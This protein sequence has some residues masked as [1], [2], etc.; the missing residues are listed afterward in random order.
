MFSARS[1]DR[2]LP[3]IAE[4]RHLKSMEGFAQLVNQERFEQLDSPSSR[5]RRH[6]QPDFACT[7]CN[8]YRRDS[9]GGAQ[10]ALIWCAFKPCPNRVNSSPKARDTQRP[11]TE[12]LEER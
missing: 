10:D 8:T 3:V 2:W 7:G 11:W 9:D 6:G 12:R 5:Q 4:H 1:L